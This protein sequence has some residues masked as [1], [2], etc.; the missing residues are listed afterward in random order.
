MFELVQQVINEHK[1]VRDLS[2][3]K[4]N[5]P[6]KQTPIKRESF[7]KSCFSLKKIPSKR[8]YPGKLKNSNLEIGNLK[9]KL[10]NVNIRINHLEKELKSL[11][12]SNLVYKKKIASLQ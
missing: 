3:T 6:C 10:E 7:M 12:T 4:P 1:N 2:L 5:K 11:K 9:Q 8:Q